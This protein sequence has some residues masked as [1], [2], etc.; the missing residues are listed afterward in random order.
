[1]EEGA[2]LLAVVGEVVV[3]WTLAVIVGGRGG[4]KG[5]CDCWERLLGVVCCVVRARPIGR[6]KVG[7][8]L[9]ENMEVVT[10]EV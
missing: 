4:Q 6:H 7:V 5:I 8:G 10:V 1:M 3:G 2:K 9:G